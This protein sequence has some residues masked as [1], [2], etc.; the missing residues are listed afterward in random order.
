VIITSDSVESLAK[1]GKLTVGSLQ[2][3]A[4]PSKPRPGE[5]RSDQDHDRLEH[6]WRAKV[7]KQQDQVAKISR[8]MK[9]IDLKIDALESHV[10]GSRTSAA[11]RRAEIKELK[12]RRAML[13]HQLTR[14]KARLGS[15]IRTA[16]Q[17]GAE[18]GWFR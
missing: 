14:E 11:R 15:L 8:A 10:V 6:S 9:R 4:T 5:P 16:R 3:R 2:D 17:Q 7:Q 18:P 13:A 1:T 12:G